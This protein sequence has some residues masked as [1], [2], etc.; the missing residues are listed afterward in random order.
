MPWKGKSQTAKK[1]PKKAAK[2]KSS[3]PRAPSQGGFKITRRVPTFGIQGSPTA[4]G[5]ILSTNP[6]LIT[7]TPTLAASGGANMYDVPFS[8]EFRLNQL[9]A[10]TDITAI[11]DKYRI[12][13]AALRLCTSNIALGAG[14]G[15]VMP[16]VQYITDH[17]DSNVPTNTIISQ[18]MG[19]RTRG[20]NTRGQLSIYCKPLPS[21]QIYGAGGAVAFSV[22]RKSPYLDCTNA[23][24]P[25]FALKGILRN[26]FLPG[27]AS[28]ANFA[29]EVVMTVHAKGLQ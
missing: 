20:F 7:G 4:A 17:D 23:D 5:T 15:L 9:D 11:A 1:A 28:V 16:W 25:H 6:M 21:V 14:A 19:V 12:V 2:K 26:V 8:V 29:A 13:S 18:K 3:V 22:P 27:T 10:Y 24:V